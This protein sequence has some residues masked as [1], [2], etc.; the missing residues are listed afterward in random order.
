MRRR[1]D[2][3]EREPG[4]AQPGVRGRSQHDLSQLEDFVHANIEEHLPASDVM[5]GVTRIA[6]S[7]EA[8][9]ASDNRPCFLLASCP[10]RFAG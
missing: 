3:R 10:R 2:D 8:A 9:F 7:S 4:T 5:V 6:A 1:R